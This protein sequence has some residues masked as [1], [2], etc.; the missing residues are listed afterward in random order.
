MKQHSPSGT[1]SFVS[2]ASRMPATMPGRDT[3]T[4]R[5]SSVLHTLDS[6]SASFRRIG[7]R[8][9]AVSLAVSLAGL[10]SEWS[11][12]CVSRSPPPVR[13]AAERSSGFR[14]VTA[15]S[16]APIVSTGCSTGCF[17]LTGRRRRGRRASPCVS[18]CSTV[19]TA[20]AID[21][22]SRSRPS[23]R[24]DWPSGMAPVRDSISTID[25]TIDAS[26]KEMYVRGE[27]CGRRRRRTDGRKRN[28][29][30]PGRGRRPSS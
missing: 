13:S 22:V 29:G 25:P 17:T 18:T 12:A 10:H 9:W 2:G 7:T 11:P 30:H 5:S 15:A 26:P 24:V 14:S 23:S 28:I 4:N 1:I 8:T 19:L 21:S 3:G 20:I 16:I 27:G 6:P